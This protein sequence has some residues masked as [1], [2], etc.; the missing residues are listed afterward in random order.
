LI[1]ALPATIAVCLWLWHPLP[2]K[3][4][5]SVY[6]PGN[7]PMRWPLAVRIA[8]I[9]GWPAGLPGRLNNPGSLAFAG[10]R[11]AVRGDRG[12]ARFTSPEEGWRALE[13]DLT[14]KV[15]R[16]LDLAGI[17]RARSGPEDDPEV[18][19]AKL[20]GRARTSGIVHP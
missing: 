20:S 4:P 10:Q 13:A 8:R 1:R 9:E 16:G 11:G 5:Q 3:A 17:A 7:C 6:V 14:A 15:A 12:F 19:L 18:Y 2:A